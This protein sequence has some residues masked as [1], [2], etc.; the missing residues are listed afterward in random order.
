M[1]ETL[2]YAGFS[3]SHHQ[4]VPDITDEQFGILC[5]FQPGEDGV[6][7]IEQRLKR[8]RGFLDPHGAID[9]TVIKLC[10]NRY[11]ELSNSLHL[12]EI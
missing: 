2:L 5:I 8:Q 4:A 12:V 6:H 1:D 3:A 9:L 11:K 7:G 10:Y